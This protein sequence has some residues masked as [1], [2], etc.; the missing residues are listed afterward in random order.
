MDPIYSS[1]I[2]IV[3][4]PNLPHGSGEPMTPE[5]ARCEAERIL[6]DAKRQAEDIRNRARADADALSKVTAQNLRFNGYDLL[7]SD[8]IRGKTVGSP[9][10][11][12]VYDHK[13]VI[14]DSLEE[15]NFKFRS[16]LK[17]RTEL[18]REIYAK[19]E[20]SILQGQK[21]LYH[22]EKD[23][24]AL[25][26]VYRNLTM[27]AATNRFFTDSIIAL[28]EMPEYAHIL[29]AV[30][31]AEK[32]I[33]ELIR[34][35]ERA[36]RPLGL[37]AYTA[38]PGEEYDDQFHEYNGDLDPYDCIVDSCTGCGMKSLSVNSD[39]GY[40]MEQIVMPALV[41]LRPIE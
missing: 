26:Q 38:Q 11:D 3:G 12:A 31:D 5:E 6:E 39:A 28:D 25:G 32:E 15:T 23:Y 20:G 8:S 40:V 30:I 29:L 17:E 19:T 21:N 1:D 9:Q 22:K 14:K 36:I 16:V 41:D 35:F 7:L 37:V 33:I 34:E 2:P 27:F 24:K 10:F 13:A 4:T 18:L